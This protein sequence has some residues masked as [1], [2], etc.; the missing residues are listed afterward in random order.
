MLIY[1][2][3]YIFFVPLK[4]SDGTDPESDCGTEKNIQTTNVFVF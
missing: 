1:I 4:C 2:D 3:A